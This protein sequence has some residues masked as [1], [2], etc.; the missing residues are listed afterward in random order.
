MGSSGIQNA[1]TDMCCIKQDG[2]EGTS[3]RLG[4]GVYR[5]GWWSRQFRAINFT[6]ALKLRDRRDVGEI[7][8]NFSCR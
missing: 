2:C 3:C 1:V 5:T 7:K 8:A 4:L 6:P